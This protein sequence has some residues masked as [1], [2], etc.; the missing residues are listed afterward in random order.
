MPYSPSFAHP[1]R[2]RSTLSINGGIQHCPLYAVVTCYAID[3]AIPARLCRR[4]GPGGLR[5][6]RD[7][8]AVE[9]VQLR[10][11]RIVARNVVPERYP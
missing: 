3:I 11:R 5:C 6:Q 9:I 1:E 4:E 2:R 8:V 10:Q 7:K